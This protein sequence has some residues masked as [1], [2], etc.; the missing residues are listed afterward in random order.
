MCCVYVYTNGF[1]MCLCCV[2]CRCVD[3]SIAMF[4]F[5][6]YIEY[7]CMI[8]VGVY[9]VVCD[10]NILYVVHWLHCY[11]VC[12]LFQICSCVYEVCLGCTVFLCFS[13]CCVCLLYFVWWCC[14]HF[15]LTYVW[16]V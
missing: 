12:V 9:S 3:T 4:M 6:L 7:A 16:F 13:L 14:M 8:C 2:C 5:A 11:I 15:Q 1:M 10:Y